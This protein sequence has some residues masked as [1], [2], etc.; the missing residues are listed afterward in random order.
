MKWKEIRS[1]TFI[2][3]RKSNVRVNKRNVTILRGWLKE[4]GNSLGLNRRRA[5]NPRS[6]WNGKF[7]VIK[8]LVAK[9]KKKE[10]IGLTSGRMQK[11]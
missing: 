3:F 2:Y 9:T 8:E 10:R 11:D 7:D 4:T 1:T 5:A 6:Q